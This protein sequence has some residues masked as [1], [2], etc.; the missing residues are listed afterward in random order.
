MKKLTLKI[1][2]TAPL[3]MHSDRL[4]NPLDKAS[5]MHKALT[6]KK[7]KTEEDNI[8]IAKSEWMGGL[9]HSQQLG[10]YMPT[11]NIR[12]TLVCG[13]KLNKLGKQIQRGTLVDCDKVKLEYNGPRDPEKMWENQEYV[14]CRS[15][16][17]QRSRLMRYRPIFPEWG[18]TTVI[19][20]DE[21]VIDEKDIIA[22]MKNAGSY[23]G[24]GDFRPDR[25]G[26]Y[27]RFSVEAI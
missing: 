12:A 7:K 19:F 16:V 10:P 6:S 22:S 5:Q 13:A 4:A 14:D 11:A 25:G 3:I 17:V 23:I 1:T 8:E 18:F 21:N 20:Y 26:S 9:Y 24:I 15:V 2:G 27:G